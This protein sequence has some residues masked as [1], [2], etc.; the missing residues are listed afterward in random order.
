[1][2]ADYN[3]YVLST[4]KLVLHAIVPM[5]LEYT[6]KAT[7]IAT[8][9]T[10]FETVNKVVFDQDGN[11]SYDIMYAKNESTLNEFISKMHSKNVRV[12]IINIS[13][14]LFIEMLQAGNGAIWY[15]ACRNGIY[16]YLLRLK[17][18]STSQT[19]ILCFDNDKALID[20]AKEL[21][22]NTNFLICKCVAHSICSAIEFDELHNQVNLYGGEE[23]YL[24]FPPEVT[25][26]LDHLYDPIGSMSK[27][28]QLR[29]CRT[30]EEFDFYTL[31]K[32][33]DV[34]ALHT[35]ICIMAYLKGNEKGI[36][37][38]ISSAMHFCE[39]LDKDET[40]K[41]ITRLHELLFEKF[42]CPLADQLNE[43]KMIHTRLAADFVEYL[44]ASEQESVGRGLSFCNASD[45]SKLKQHL[46]LIRSIDDINVNEMLANF[47]RL[48][49]I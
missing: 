4:S 2:S 15:S 30:S 13:N 17:L 29:F 27:R 24:Y 9:N 7:L 22:K 37:F 18:Y 32:M 48:M 39:L 28:V 5:L 35:M 34:N 10:R 3:N 46:P 49:A 21:Y 44:F 43:K 8:T 16:D 45:V 11:M 31:A 36:S 23:C 25:K 33:I 19:N 40:K 42:L 38:E 1:M 26:L 12:G 41:I 14:P 6:S 47:E 20:R